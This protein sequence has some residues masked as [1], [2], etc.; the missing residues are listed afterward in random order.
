MY[1]VS[2]RMF[3]SGQDTGPALLQ[4]ILK[5]FTNYVTRIVAKEGAMMTTTCDAPCAWFHIRV[6]PIWPFG[7]FSSHQSTSLPARTRKVEKLRFRNTLWCLSPDRLDWAS[8]REFYWE[9][10]KKNRKSRGRVYWYWQYDASPQGT[11]PRTLDG[12]RDVLI[13]VLR[14]ESVGIVAS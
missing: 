10:D 8:V 9:F 5:S 13:P 7:L 14:N 4:R 6:A 1:R 2:R 11:L 3:Y 12:N